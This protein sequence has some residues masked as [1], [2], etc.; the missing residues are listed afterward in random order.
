M[1]FAGD[2]SGSTTTISRHELLDRDADHNDD[3]GE[4]EEEELNREELTMVE[5]MAPP[6]Y[7]EVASIRSSETQPPTYEEAI[8]TS[9]LAAQN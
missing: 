2:N 3:D 6:D 8:S 5:P 9:N 4:E 1:N 7:E